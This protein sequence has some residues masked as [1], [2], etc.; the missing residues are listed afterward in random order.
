MP[1]GMEVDLDPGHIVLGGA[2]LPR[3]GA[4]QP[5][6]LGPYLLSLTVAISV[7]AEVL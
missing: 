1:V 2:Q 3:K 4:Q 5:P 7:T 6:L